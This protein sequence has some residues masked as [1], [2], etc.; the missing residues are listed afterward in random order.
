MEIYFVIPG[1]H[2]PLP[3]C[4]PAIGKFM[5]AD[6]LWKIMLG[7]FPNAP[8]LYRPGINFQKLNL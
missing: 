5:Q 4:A 3:F 7:P 2:P 6:V 8:L 1:Q